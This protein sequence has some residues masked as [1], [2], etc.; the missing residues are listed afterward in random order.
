VWSD[1][2][3]ASLA[4]ILRHS[5][6]RGKLRGQENLPGRGPA[7]LVA[8]HAGALGPIALCASLR[9]RLYPWVI[10]DMLNPGLAAPYLRTDFTTRELGLSGGFSTAVSRLLAGIAVS[11]LRTIECVPVWSDRQVLATYRQSLDYLERGRILLIFP[12]DPSQPP[13]AE[14]GMR[15]FK[16][17]FARLGRLFYSR[18][19]RRLPFLP[20]AVSQS[21]RTIRVGAP[22]GLD[23]L[24]GG[25]R[26]HIA[27]TEKLETGIGAMLR[28]HASSPED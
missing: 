3:Y 27:I 28:G 8:N 7:V 4:W 26:Q 13:D 25:G 16:P 20:A 2:L 24:G 9:R 19:G 22:E 23:P 10:A 15:P 14:T 11:L 5:L 17:G 1:L 18:T 6:W 12:E 21:Q